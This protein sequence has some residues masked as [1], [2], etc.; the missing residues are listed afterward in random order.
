MKDYDKIGWKLEVENL[1]GNCIVAFGI[2]AVV[3]VIL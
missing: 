3:C 1:I 2:G